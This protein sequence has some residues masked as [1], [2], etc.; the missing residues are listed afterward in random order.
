MDHSQ[1]QYPM[2][3]NMNASYLTQRTAM[4]G[5]ETM[6]HY[7]DNPQDVQVSLISKL[8]FC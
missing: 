2:N 8:F 7:K 5:I 6:K 3:M 1:Y 4:T